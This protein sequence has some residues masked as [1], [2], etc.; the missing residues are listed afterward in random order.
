MLASYRPA[1][2]ILRSAGVVCCSVRDGV[3][4]LASEAAATLSLAET[5][6]R[7]FSGVGSAAF[8]L[9]E[10]KADNENRCTRDG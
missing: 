5:C 7:T 10:T 9:P 4:R 8:G 3:V 2:L 1:G 6:R